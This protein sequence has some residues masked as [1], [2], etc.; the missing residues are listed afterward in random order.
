MDI[1]IYKIEFTREGSKIVEEVSLGCEEK[2]E[3]EDS[4]KRVHPSSKI[5]SCEKIN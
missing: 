2:Q 3:A 5:L 4:F 1:D